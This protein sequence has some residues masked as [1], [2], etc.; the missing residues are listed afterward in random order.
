MNQSDLD[1]TYIRR[2]TL[3]PLVS[4]GLALLALCI[5]V[6]VHSRHEQS[7]AELNANHVA[8]NQ[9]YESLVN[10]RRIVDRYH[11]RY[12]KFYELGFIG[13]ESR[14]DVVETM[15]T[16]SARLNLPRVTYSIEPQRGV[17]APVT[18]LLGGENI[19][20]RVSKLQLE[21][22]LLHEFDLLRFFDVLQSQAPGLIKVDQCEI[23]SLGELSTNAS[24]PNLAANCDVNIFSVIT[25]DVSGGTT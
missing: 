6:W 20:I 9:D 23:A 4:A 5:A 14:L 11:R 22:G 17:V 24:D 3:I 25:S 2:Y 19:Q 1:W 21:M 7:F 18:S 12:Q 13:R 15:R 16:T 8:V 10:Q